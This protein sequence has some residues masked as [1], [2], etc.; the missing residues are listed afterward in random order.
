MLVVPGIDP[1]LDLLV[2]GAFAAVK[3]GYGPLDAGNLSFIRVEILVE[4]LGGEE[5]AGA[6]ST[7]GE[8]F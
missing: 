4:R 6:P 3:R 2:R 5:G 8:L 1:V 7:L